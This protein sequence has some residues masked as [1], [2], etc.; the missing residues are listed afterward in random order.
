MSEDDFGVGQLALE[1]SDDEVGCC[2]ECLVADLLGCR[3]VEDAE[4]VWR[5]PGTR[6]R[7]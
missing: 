2:F 1:T 3:D 7:R 4:V 6:A 5:M